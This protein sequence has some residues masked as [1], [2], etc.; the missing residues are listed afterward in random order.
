MPANLY[1]LVCSPLTGQVYISK[2]KDNVMLD[3]RKEV[4]LQ[5]FMEC[6]ATFVKAKGCDTVE[7][8]GIS[9]NDKQGKPLI[10]IKYHK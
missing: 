6:I 10:T 7:T 2:T 9:V 1:K 8:I 3:D 4:D 5:E